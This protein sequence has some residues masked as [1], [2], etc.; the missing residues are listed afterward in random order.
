MSETGVNAAAG[1]DS[2][3]HS[4][5]PLSRKINKIL[6]TRLENDKD[7]L[8]AL[9]ALAT[10]FT[11][12]NVQ[13]RRNLRSDIERRSLGIQEEFVQCF[14]QVTEQLD[15]IYQDV[16]AMNDCCNDMTS[17]LQA[18][19]A[20]T[21]DL[22][23]QT[24][25]LQTEGQRLQLRQEVA[26]GFL[27]TFQLRPEEVK[28]LR[29]GTRDTALDVGFFAALE[30][31]KEIHNDCKLLL[32]TKQQTAGLEIM[33]S[34][35]LHQEAAYERLYRWTQ[36]ECRLLNVDSPDVA[37]RLCQ[38]M[39]SLQDRPVLFKYSID[40]FSTAR[41]AA[42]VRAFIDALTRGGPGRGARPIELHSH[43]P[44]RYVGDMLG[45]LHQATASE[46][47]HL[48]A[49]FKLCKK[50]PVEEMTQ[51]A[52]GHIMEGV[53]RPLKVRA[54][55]VIVSEPGAVTLYKLSN[56]LKFY[57]NTIRQVLSVE[58]TALLTTLEEMHTLGH[59]MFFNSL[60]CHATKLM[61]KV[62]LP[63]A[64]LGP[65]E[66]LGR[67]LTLLREV[68]AC[69]DSSVVSMD[70]KQKDYAQILSYVIDPLLQM[71]SLS[72][73]QLTSTD[74]AAYML[75]CV[76]LIHSMVSLYEFTDQRLEM[77]QAQLD[78]HLDTLVSEQGSHILSQTHLGLLY[79][80][81]QHHQVSKVHDKLVDVPG[82]DTQAIV[83]AMAKFDNFLA[84]PDQFL[85][86]QAGL[87][88][89]AGLRQTLRQRTMELVHATY[90][91]IY[92]KLNDASSGYADPMGLMSKTPEQIHKLLI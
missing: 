77:L 89:G 38:A 33:E 58:E 30:R 29:G 31:V 28:A 32:R 52:A 34:M 41:R 51:Q 65:T 45:W 66:A 55:Q 59:K 85:L 11:D 91:Q 61:E 13:S 74:M 37:P 46:R 48:E 72:A 4:S 40:E 75:N 88:L 16:L 73:S 81:V 64:D 69:H 80:A 54:E 21:R 47:E 60:N 2:K 25:K 6:D 1:G 68:L 82:M 39:E 12:N 14:R 23:G 92:D 17:R 71:C 22:I 87:L 7:T 49:L 76:Y 44:M 86:P 36:G 78:A 26:T 57:Q 9:K 67:T 5:N 20:Q 10:F 3:P 53:C 62:E 50:M 15:L 19:K 18:T 27:T 35:A 63:P 83:K 79:S 84:S 43:D 42:V 70:N 90:R 8:E 24:T 56:L